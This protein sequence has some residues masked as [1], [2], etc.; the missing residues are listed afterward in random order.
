MKAKKFFL[1]AFAA[2]CALT[3]ATLFTSCSSDDDNAVKDYNYSI[4]FELIS[5]SMSTDLDLDSD[6]GTSLSPAF[7]VWRE[8]ILT[9]YRTALGVNSDNFTLNGTQSD[10]DARVLEACKAAEQA[11]KLITGGT[12]TVTVYNETAKKNVYSYTITSGK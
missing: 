3:A 5:F 1:A 7:Q 9:V 12:A 4:Q 2:M 10:C 8:S 6:T 11:A